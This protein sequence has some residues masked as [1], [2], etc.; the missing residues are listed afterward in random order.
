MVD[1]FLLASIRLPSLISCGE[2]VDTT[3]AA[4]TEAVI[5]SAV[6][7]TVAAGTEAVVASAVAGTVAV[8]TGVVASAAGAHVYSSVAHTCSVDRSHRLLVL[9]V[10]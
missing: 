3:P 1:L 9:E 10:L 4:G 7:G 2:A 6:V 8:H 5:A